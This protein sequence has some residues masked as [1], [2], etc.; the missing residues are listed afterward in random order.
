[1]DDYLSIPAIINPASTNFTVVMW[2]KA[3]AFEATGNTVILQ[4]EGGS[5]RTWLF[6]TSA[7]P[8]SSF[9][10]GTTTAG[11]TSLTTGT[12]YHVG[13]TNTSGTI[14]IYLDGAQDGTNSVTPESEASIFRLG[15]HKNTT[16]AEWNGPVDEVY[17]YD[18]AL[19]LAEIQTIYALQ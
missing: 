3:D 10:G 18:R 12:W 16:G 7:G 14:R 11:T 6:R 15:D 4:Q 5:G 8:I 19:S 2:V 17:I 1:V 9:V 13:L